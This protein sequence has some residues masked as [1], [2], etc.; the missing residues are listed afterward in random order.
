MEEN[1][2]TYQSQRER[3]FGFVQNDQPEDDYVDEESSFV[4]EDDYDYDF[5]NSMN[6]VDFSQ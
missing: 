5:D 6:D 3:L 4:D 1:E 2:E